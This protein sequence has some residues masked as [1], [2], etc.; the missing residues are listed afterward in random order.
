MRW[1]IALLEAWTV[2]LSSGD[3]VDAIMMMLEPL[4]LPPVCAY[5]L[6]HRVIGHREE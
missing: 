5:A 6:A 3:A 4:T 2:G 1:P